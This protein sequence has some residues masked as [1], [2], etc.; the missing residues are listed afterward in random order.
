M[1]VNRRNFLRQT[2]LIAATP[3]IINQLWSCTPSSKTEEKTTDSTATSSIISEPSVKD[4]GLQLWTVQKEMAL[5]PKGTLKA[6][7]SYGYKQIE[8]FQGEKGV[9]WG[10]TAKEFKT[11]MDELGMNIIS[12]HCNPEYTMKKE[13]EKEFGKLVDDAASIGMKYLINPF[14]GSLKTADE[15]KKAA[16]GLNRQG[17]M[18]AKAGLRV[19]YHNHNFEFKKFAD[20]TMPEVILL[21]GTDPKLVDFEMDIFW[22]V[23]AGE[24]PEEWL[25]KYNN[26]FKLCHIKDL[27]KDE[28]VAE[29]RKNKNEVMI[30]DDVSASCDLGTGKIDFA[31][32][33]STSKAN[34]IEYFIVEQERFDNTTPL[35]AVEADANYMKK[36]VFA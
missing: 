7:A 19:A 8:S 9:F 22:V 25:K 30:L 14:L 33:L 18:A 11:Y 28:K 2:G 13:T 3:L 29:L 23:K 15:W 21:E 4:F 26:R 32:I 24:N 6:L 34:G 12:T 27:Y 20:G 17:E 31:K 36:L 1:K 35:K 5:D 16:E 10:M